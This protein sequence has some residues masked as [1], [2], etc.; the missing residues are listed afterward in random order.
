MLD[1]QPFELT[2]PPAAKK[3]VVKK[4]QKD[5]TP[6]LSQFTT[7]PET[8]YIGQILYIKP[9]YIVSVPEFSKVRDWKSAKR[10]MNERNLAN[11]KH[12]SKL[13][14]KA[15]QRIKNAINWLVASAK[16]QKVWS[17]STKKYYTFKVN[18]ITL[19]LPDTIESIK[20]REF[21]TKLMHPFMVYC[22][23][24][25]GL[26]NYVWKVEYQ[27]NGKLHVHIT[28][29]TFISY[30]LIRA[31]WNRLLKKNG[32][33]SEFEKKYKHDNPNSTDVHAVWKVDDLGAYISKY[34]SKD[35]DP[36]HT[37]N[38]RIWGCSYDLS[39]KNKCIV[40][41]HAHEV[42]EVLRPLFNPKIKYKAIETVDKV[43]GR[44]FKNAEVFMVS[45]K[46]WETLIFGRIKEAYDKHRFKI[47]HA[48]SGITELSTSY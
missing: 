30:H 2:P 18:L 39:D 41:A 36:E 14:D 10:V 7:T 16:E 33:M 9:T 15:K 20:E 45:M 21:K 28:T 11:N 5:Y 6:N 1:T 26:K 40:S 13:S 25:F 38:G 24:Y 4:V 44:V 22:K 32:Y 46:E 35:N 19:T 48:L 43:T 8:T 29:D 34:M 12:N 37:L 42:R 27:K 23:K 47:R 17:E 3:R 31:T